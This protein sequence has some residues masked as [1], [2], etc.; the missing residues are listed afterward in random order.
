MTCS[1]PRRRID[2]TYEA[3]PPLPQSV[4]FTCL[5]CGTSGAIFW[6]DATPDDQDAALLIAR[7]MRKERAGC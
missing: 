2:G 5:D 6:P 7:A 1:H 3:I 4:A